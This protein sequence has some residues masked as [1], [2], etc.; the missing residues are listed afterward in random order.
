GA[1]APA[2]TAA[3]AAPT[4]RAFARS[5]LALEIDEARA[6]GTPLDVAL[7]GIRLSAAASSARRAGRVAGGGALVFIE[8]TSAKLRDHFAVRVPQLLDRSEVRHRHEIRV[9]LR[10]QRHAEVLPVRRGVDVGDERRRADLLD[11]LRLHVDHGELPVGVIIDER[12]VVRVLEQTLIV[13]VL[14]AN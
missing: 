7:S 8:L 11:R 12:E 3:R 4:V 9:R 1:A 6:D 5:Q 13:D 14:P 10:L 2:A